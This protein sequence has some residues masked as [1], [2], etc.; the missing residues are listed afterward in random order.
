[1]MVREEYYLKEEIRCLKKE[2]RHQK[3]QLEHLEKELKYPAGIKEGILTDRE[4]MVLHFSCTSTI[5]QLTD[6]PHRDVIVEQ[7]I[8]DI[9]KNRCRSLSND[10]IAN[11]LKAIEGE[12]IMGSILM[13]DLMERLTGYG[14]GKHPN[15]RFGTG[16]SDMK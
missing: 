10:D 11:L 14:A 1:M 9:R 3:R 4:K 6:L 15:K 13:N 2:I 5:A 12:M 8:E 16:W 7:M